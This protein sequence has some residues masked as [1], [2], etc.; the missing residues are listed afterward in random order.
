MKYLYWTAVAVALITLG[1]TLGPGP[2][3]VNGGRYGRPHIYVPHEQARATV[4]LFSEAG[5]WSPY[6]VQAARS[7]KEHGVLAIGIDSDRYLEKISAENAKCQ[8]LVRDAEFVSMAA[9]RALSIRNYQTPVVA[10][11]GIGAAIAHTVQEQA[12][13][14]TIGGLIRTAGEPTAPPR[15][16]LCDEVHSA[17]PF[18]E[19]V[20]QNNVQA[21]VA[22]ILRHVP[23]PPAKPD[24]VAAL[25]LVELPAKA[26][27]ERIAVVLTGDGGWRD[28]DKEISEHLQHD[29]VPVVGWDSLRYFWQ[30]KTSTETG[31]ALAHLLQHYTQAWRAS[32]ITLIGYSFGANVL[33]FAYNRLPPELKSRVDQVVLLA[34][35]KAA[36]FQ[37]RISGW[38]GISPTDNADALR[39]EVAAIPP[40]NLQ[41][42]YGKAEDDSLCPTLHDKSVNIVQTSGGHHF[43]GNYKRLEQQ[44]LSFHRH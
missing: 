21:L 9:Q 28:L 27:S 10:G 36:E 41:C 31:L 6:D 37:I 12:P 11:I 43:D 39:Q 2:S 40:H 7:L 23:G 26:Q 18:D 22:A 1:I 15:I 29:G 42:F 34:P 8:N 24:S 5:G 32:K 3:T 19:Q 44:I 38:M 4:I 35:A 30:E 33:P 17:R 25:P 13:P 16:R 20:P 14:N